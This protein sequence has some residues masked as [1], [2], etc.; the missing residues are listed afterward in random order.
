MHMIIFGSFCRKKE[1][2]NDPFVQ[3]FF[4]LVHGEHFKP[5]VLRIAFDIFQIMNDP[6]LHALQK[7]GNSS[8]RQCLTTE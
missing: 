6:S 8:G 7:H 3:I 1:N 5:K 4:L 2:D